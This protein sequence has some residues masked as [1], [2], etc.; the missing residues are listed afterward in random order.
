MNDVS[1]ANADPASRAPGRT[2][3][4]LI[5]VV[6]CDGSGKSTVT[7]ALCAWLSGYAPTQICHLGKQ[8]GNVGRSLA[9]LPL[10]GKRVDKTVQS[11]A[12]KANS[13]KGPDGLAAFVIWMFVLRRSRRFARMLSLRAAGNW[14]IADRFPQLAMPGAMD[15]PGL[16]AAAKTGLV[17]WF[18]RDE[19][20]RFEAMTATVPDLVLRLNVPL[21][22]ACARKPDHRPGALAGK[23]ANLPHLSFNGAPIVDL[24]STR[25]LEDVIAAAREAIA[26]RF[27]LRQGTAPASAGSG[28]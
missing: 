9:K 21:D 13:D 12:K 16:D 1:K 5:A 17:G 25:P 28:A 11:R 10:L 27:G 26:Q 8:S 19:R 7:E 6:G 3:P 2:P 22:V 4:P 14:I 24:D 18:S 20:R 15:G 23:I